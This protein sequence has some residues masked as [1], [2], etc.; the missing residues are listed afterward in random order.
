MRILLVIL[1]ATSGV[2]ALTSCKQAPK[3][4]NANTAAKTTPEI[5][6]VADRFA[7]IQMLR[8]TIPGFEELSLPQKQL[9]YYLYMAGMSG[10]DIFYDQ[11]NR[12]NLQIR[13][14]LETILETYQGDKNEDNYKKFMVYAKR[15]FFSNG[16]HHHYSTDKM[17]PE[18]DPAF[19]DTLISK[20][21]YSKMPNEGKK[22]EEFK[23]NII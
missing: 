3:Q 1:T 23:T 8:Y 11:K 22:I 5:E 10:R 15:F 21:D 20:S 12:Y 13:K 6:I 4:E 18:F 16:I 19:L 17:I 14:T 7:D 2:L 9:A